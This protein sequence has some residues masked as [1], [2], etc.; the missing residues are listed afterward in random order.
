MTELGLLLRKLLRI[1]KGNDKLIRRVF[2]DQ[3]CIIDGKISTNPPSEV[4]STSLQSA[5]DPDATYRKKQSQKVKGYSVNLT[6]TCNQEGLNLVTHI[7]V[8]PASAADNQQV[9]A[10]I[11]QT[12]KIV[13]T[14]QEV[15]LDGAYHRKGDTVN[16]PDDKEQ[17]KRFYYTGLQG[18]RGRFVYRPTGDGLEAIDTR[19]GEVQQAE[20]YKRGKFKIHIDGKQHYFKQAAI[21]ACLIRNAIEAMPT[22]IRNRR[23]NVEAGLFQLCYYT[24]NNKTR[25]RGQIK[26]SMWANSRAVWMN[27]IRIKNHLVP[28]Q[29]RRKSTS[30]TQTPQQHLLATLSGAVRAVC[31]EF[32]KVIRWANPRFDAH[33]IYATIVPPIW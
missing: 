13:G 24:R 6:E 27:F 11:E 5:H 7:K 10:A 21:N 12:E 26:H 25:Y 2:D 30:P 9:T 29:R 22:E 4:S 18:P 8:N 20:E 28:P 32:H 15:S 19:T 17:N 31:K 16:P 33:S 3:Y 1:Y 23:N 14:V